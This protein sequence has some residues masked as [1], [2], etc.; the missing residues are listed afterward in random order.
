MGKTIEKVKLWNIFDEE[1]VIEVEAQID[2]GATTVVLPK[3]IAGELKL[4]IVRQTWVKYAN[5]LREKKDVA[6]GLIIEIK[7]RSTICE[8][9]IEPKRE[10]PLVGQFVLE[11]LDLWI[12]SKN[13]QLMPNPES[14]DAPMLEALLAGHP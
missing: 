5:D 7:G 10:E 12:D 3:K 2:N 6:R 8:A 13:G 14:P 1:K 4:P 9:I 11:M